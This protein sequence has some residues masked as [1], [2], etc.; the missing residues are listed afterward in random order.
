MCLGKWQPLTMVNRDYWDLWG[1]LAQLSHAHPTFQST[2]V[3]TLDGWRATSPHS[4]SKFCVFLNF[5]LALPTAVYKNRSQCHGAPSK[6]G[7]N[8]CLLTYK[9]VWLNSWMKCELS[10]K[11]PLVWDHTQVLFLE[12]NVTGVFPQSWL[13]SEESTNFFIT[14][15]FS[16]FFEAISTEHIWLF[17]AEEVTR[18][19]IWANP[20]PRDTVETWFSSH[21]PS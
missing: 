4:N 18:P 3:N 17:I 2:V 8:L 12:G 13:F 14:G 11:H 7:V 19:H 21:S 6:S 20:K 5:Y 1:V 10:R 9:T 15:Y 16:L